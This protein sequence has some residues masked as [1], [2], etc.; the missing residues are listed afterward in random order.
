[1]GGLAWFFGVIG[2]LGMVMGIVTAVGVIPQFGDELT[3]TFWFMLSGLLFL[4][5]IALA[6]GSRGGGGEY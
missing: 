4:A 1:M 6:S 5:S 3:W 2:G